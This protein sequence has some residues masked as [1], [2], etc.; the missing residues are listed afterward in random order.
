MIRLIYRYCSDCKEYSLR[1]VKELPDNDDTIGILVGPDKYGDVTV[2]L[3]DEMW[4]KGV[5]SH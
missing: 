1:E 3:P 5:I 2:D 4:P